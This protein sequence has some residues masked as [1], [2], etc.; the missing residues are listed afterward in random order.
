MFAYC[1]NCPV[2]YG[3]PTGHISK[4]TFAA[5]FDCE[6]GECGTPHLVEAAYAATVYAEV[7]GEN[8]RTKQ[9]VAHVINNRMI[10]GDWGESL[11]F[12]LSAPGQF[13][14]YGNPMFEDAMTYYATGRWDNPIEQ[15]AMDDCMTAVR[16]ITREGQ[17]D[18]TGGAL[19]FNSLLGPYDWSDADKFTLIDVPGTEGVWFYK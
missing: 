14:G 18:F 7:A 2:V 9:A 6:G 15:K 10:C 5:V 3:D 19:Y 12:V 17:K 13:N 11:S 1:N 8:Y 16:E 4:Y